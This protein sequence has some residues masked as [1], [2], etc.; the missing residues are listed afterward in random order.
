MAKSRC[1]ISGSSG[2]LRHAPFEQPYSQAC[3]VRSAMLSKYPSL[4]VLYGDAAQLIAS[5]D[6][7]EFIGEEA[8]VLAK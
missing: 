4:P 6:G 2:S 8:G 5:P 1:S 3:G 7:T